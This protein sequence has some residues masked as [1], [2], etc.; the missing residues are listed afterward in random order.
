MMNETGSYIEKLINDERYAD[1]LNN[2]YNQMMK[3]NKY[4]RRINDIDKE[5][6]WFVG[7]KKTNFK[8]KYEDFLR[9]AFDNYIP[10]DN[11]AVGY[12][13]YKD[14]LGD[15]IVDEDPKYYFCLCLLGHYRNE[16][17]KY[18]NVSEKDVPEVKML[19]DKVCLLLRFFERIEPLV[20]VCMNFSDTEK[21]EYLDDDIEKLDALAIKHR[22]MIALQR[23]DKSM[24]FKLLGRMRDLDK[25]EN[26][27]FEGLAHYINGEYEQAIRYAKRIKE[28][29]IDYPSG[30]ALIL[31]CYALAGD[32]YGFIEFFHQIKYTLNKWHFAYLL[33]SL[34]IRLENEDDISFV[35]ASDNIKYIDSCKFDES[36]DEYYKNL[37]VQLVADILIEG[38]LVIE[39]K[40][41]HDLVGCVELSNKKDRR[42]KLLFQALSLFPEGQNKYLDE[43]YYKDKK[44][45]EVK[46]DAERYILELLLNNNEYKDFNKYKKAFLAVLKLGDINGFLNIISINFDGLAWLADN[47]EQSAEE[48]LRLA[49]IEGSVIGNIDERVKKRIEDENLDF[50]ND[51]TDRKIYDFLSDQGRL[52]F[53]AA[54]WQYE[55]SSEEDYGWR[56]AG[57]ISLSYYRIIELELNTKVIVPLISKIEYQI[58]KDEFDNKKNTFSSDS[59]K[60]RYD[61]KWTAVLTI[62]EKINR[63]EFD[64]RGLMLGAVK[65]FFESIGSKY[66][67]GDPVSSIIKSKLTEIFNEQ[68]IGKFEEGFFETITSDSN[69]NKFRNPPA[70][71]R[72]LTY[73]TACECRELFRDTMK[74]LSEMLK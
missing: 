55:K 39:E 69:R 40:D 32:A 15:C 34:V 49:Y 7:N 38:I 54:E 37:L 64:G 24:S 33:I 3:V 19:F 44:I 46:T 62:A 16:L 73:N 27:Y 26:D 4:K 10:F 25:G 47:G 72:Y 14:L 58:L 28:D 52:A 51:I 67:S 71:S 29:E 65:M 23:R 41:V 70:H 35:F 59:Q 74:Q 6:T 61:K 56:D 68:G 42:L 5:I 57:M 45:S 21:T 13:K 8:P 1:E 66:D 50:S 60:K 36:I 63:D 9:H 2:N 20:A 22:F 12:Y 53:E 17:R 48:L 18:E 31:E 30:M 43:D 11:N